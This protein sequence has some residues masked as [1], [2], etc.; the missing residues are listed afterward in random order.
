MTLEIGTHIYYKEQR[1]EI[2]N[3][4]PDQTRCLILIYESKT[5]KDTPLQTWV[6]SDDIIIDFQFYRNAAINNILN[7]PN[8]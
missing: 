7:D 1:G 6:S 3:I 2:L 8:S 4:N 5:V